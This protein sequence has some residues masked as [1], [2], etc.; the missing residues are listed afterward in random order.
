MAEHYQSYLFPNSFLV[1]GR[2]LNWSGF[3]V[4][5]FFLGGGGGG[6]FLSF[7][8]DFIVIRFFFFFS[9]YLMKTVFRSALTLEICQLFVF[10]SISRSLCLS[11]H[12]SVCLLV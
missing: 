9:V 4:A 8:S 12:L 10:L 1:N 5:F 7:F 6:F 11:V 3:D 2:I